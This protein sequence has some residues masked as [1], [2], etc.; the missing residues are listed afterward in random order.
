MT[1][2]TPYS[3]NFYIGDSATSIFPFIF[4]EINPAFV[5]VI[6]LHSDGDISV[7][8]YTVDIDSQR[9]IFGEETQIPT[10]DDVVCIY[11][12]TPV[13]QDT[14]FRTL[15]GY[16]AQALENILSKIV[17]MIQEIKSTYFSTDVLQGTPWQ[18][19]L[20][21]SSDDGATVQIDYVARKLV[22]GLYFQINNGNLQVSAD[23]NSY[24]TMP[25]SS[26]IVEFRQTQTIKEDLTVEYRLQYRIGNTWYNAESNAEATADAA[27]QVAE[28]ARDIAQDAKDIAQDA[29]ETAEGI[30]DIAQEALDKVTQEITDREDADE[31]L[32]DQID[33]L[34]GRGRFLALWNC[35]TGLAESNPPES[36]YPYK[37]G[38][39]FVVGTVSSADPAV[40]YKP[41]GSSYTTG[42][43]STTVETNEVSVNDT[44]FYDGTVW[45]L[46]SNAQK[47][48]SFS[49][50]A[51]SPYDNTA[52]G[53]ALDSKQNT[54][55]AGTNISIVNDVISSTAQESFFRGKWA[56]WANV[57]SVSSGYPADYHGNHTPEQN[58]YMVVEDA[59]G[60]V[61][62]ENVITLDGDYRS[63]VVTYAG[64]SETFE[65]PNAIAYP[66]VTAA[67]GKIKIARIYGN[68]SCVA[69]EDNL[70]YGNNIYNKDETIFNIYQWDSTRY[71]NKIY[72]NSAI[73]EGTWRFGY[74][75]SWDTEGKAGW[76]PEYQVEDVLPTAS[77]TEAGIAKLYTTT[78]NNTD[79]SMTQGSIT[80]ALDGKQD[81]L[82]AGTN[83]SIVNNVISATTQES[84]FRG[85]F[86]TWSDVPTSDSG[87]TPD[88]S[89]SRT[90]T[91][92]DYMVVED[93]SGYVKV[94]AAIDIYREPQDPQTGTYGARFVC[95]YFDT[96]VRHSVGSEGIIIGTQGNRLKITYASYNWSVIPLDT[97]LIVDGV[98]KPVNEVAYS[99]YYLPANGQLVKT[100]NYASSG[101]YEGTWRFAYHGIW[102]VEGKNGWVAEY[103]VEDVLPTADSSTAG[104][105]K[106]Y[107]TTGS[108]T[109]GAID[110]NGTTTA[111]NT[112]VS[113]HNT[114][115]NAHSNIRGTANG[116]AT[117][118][119]NAK[120]PLTQINDALLGNVSY[121]GLWN[122]ATNDPFL[123]NPSGELPT[124]YTQYGWIK[125]VSG[126]PYID[127]GIS[128]DYANEDEITVETKLN[129][130]STA[131]AGYGSLGFTSGNG[132][133][134]IWKSW[135]GVPSVNIANLTATFA[136][137]TDTVISM[138]VD[139][140]LGQKSITID[141]TTTYGAI[142]S[143]F[144]NLN[145]YVLSI[146]N[147]GTPS[148]NQSY[149]KFYYVNISKGGTLLARLL[150]CKRNS[151]DAIGMYDTVRNTFYP[152]TSGVAEV[153]G[154]I[155][156]P[157]GHYYIT[158]VA[159]DQFNM[160]FEVGDWII[161]NGTSWTKVLNTDAVSSVEGRTGNVTVINDNAST[162]DTTYTW[163]ADKLE[164][165]FANV[166]TVNNPTI[167][168][169]QGGVTKGSFTLN[170]ATGDT[171]ALDAGGGGSVPDATDQV[172]GIAKLYN[173]Y[174]LNI[175]GSMTQSA[176]TNEII[177]SVNTREISEGAWIDSWFSS[178][179][180][181]TR[182]Y[183]EDIKNQASTTYATYLSTLSDLYTNR[184]ATMATLKIPYNSGRTC[185]LYL[186]DN[187]EYYFFLPKDGKRLRVYDDN[188]TIKFE[189][190]MFKDFAL[191]SDLPTVNDSTITITQGGV[192]KGSFTLN[193][194]SG[195]TIA[196]DAGSGGV[197][198]FQEPT[199]A[200][201]YTWYRKYADGWV[202]QGGQANG[203]KTVSLPI[204]MSDAN[205]E[206][207]I[208]V[209]YDSSG[210]ALYSE[211]GFIKHD[212]KTTT[213]FTKS[214]NA[215]IFNW[216]VY[217]M[218]A[219]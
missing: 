192:T 188:G 178:Y 2:T 128:Y 115:S 177:N 194:A 83:I 189:E 113:T 118:D 48:V 209:L 195:D 200:N 170:Q 38:D 53:N 121:Q 176:I 150:P 167:T 47:E 33:N 7:P 12:E 163:S 160:H 36:P 9:V 77:P 28:Q 26:D 112:A 217:G 114:A 129:Y 119:A 216:V 211:L 81:T 15:E 215:N 207:I 185:Y 43:A 90:P 1:L 42:V 199:A 41:D 22:K 103:Q 6:V 74:Y 51:G 133:M 219:N 151:D 153:G 31:A 143:S 75:G 96:T 102:S 76:K 88:Y 190:A 125:T 64:A 162:G 69:N 202:E 10:E 141:G 30:E 45:K 201:N 21:K 147:G 142:T 63:V 72:P 126:T 101:T 94:G 50:L 139:K 166:P 98:E 124:G 34:S 60:Y 134:Y 132:F 179:W 120:V 140:T 203:N 18:L 66:Y 40:N 168:I 97:P 71:D 173:T 159:G 4:D 25:K 105:A 27:L 16:N 131:R 17:G 137:E 52:L 186:V 165:K 212:S 95:E 79:G 87:Y 85:K 130:L 23:G 84:F 35:A 180:S 214:G 110:Q 14:P 104:I 184:S 136:S 169:T 56:N 67:D 204:T 191:M 54:L 73:Y 8:T 65:F 161:S 138:K 99:F 213:S 183:L 197:T 208:N 148:S 149:V 117:L 29:K 174:G 158:S 55:T 13:I 59:S 107:T 127:T 11:R 3:A 39:Y 122:A 172:K 62:A 181:G 111:I 70:R 164:T 78:G 100:I 155:E 156:I 32:Q 145:I 187:N 198:E 193:Q 89:G 61:S 93:S 205:Y 206:T 24:I 86:L 175:D 135:S 109:D 108:N 144:A 20:L 58:D 182:V 37:A 44:Y 152:V 80:T 82:T 92:N 68:F 218:A 154:E 210:Y 196:L 171:I 123:P 46:Q 116:L 57:P 5:K 19:D 146:N 91:E 157:K 106:L 49:A